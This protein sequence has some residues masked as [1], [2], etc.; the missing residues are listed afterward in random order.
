MAGLILILSCGSDNDDPNG[1]TGN[2][3]NLYLQI[4]PSGLNV[5][6]VSSRE[7]SHVVPLQV[8][9]IG[10]GTHSDFTAQIN[11]WTEDDLVAYNNKEK[12]SY[13]LLPSSLYSLS[14]KELAFKQ[15]E[16]VVDVEIKFAPS[17]VFNEFKKHGSEYVIALKLT[18]DKL[19]IR[20]RQGDILLPISFDYPIIHFATSVAEVSV[21]KDQVPVTIN[22]V[23]DFKE[24][25]KAITN[26]WNFACKFSVPANAEELVAAYNQSYKTSCQLLPANNYDLGEGASFQTGNNQGTGEITIKREGLAV[27]SYLLPLKLDECSN[28]GVVCRDE[29]CYLQVGKTYSNPIITDKSVPDPCVIRANDGYFY[30]YATHTDKYWMPIYRS[31]DLVNW[32][33]LRTAFTNAT[34][35]TLPGGGSFWA[36]EIKYINGKYVLYFS[37][38]KMNGADVS[39][40]AVATSDSPLGPFVPSIEL[41]G[42]A[43]FGSNAIDQFYYEEDGKKY[44]FF[45]SFKGIFVVELADDGLSVKRDI[46]GKPV[47]KK[48]VCG[49]AFEGTNI[50]KKDGYY[51]LFASIGSCCA[52]VNSSYKVV[53]G[54]STNL[55][56]PY[57]DKTGKDMLNNAW[58]LV[59]EGDGQKWIGPGHNAEIIRDDE[60][61]DWM[62]YHSYVKKN[63]AVGGRLGM[64]D[65]LHWSADGWPT[66]KKC[67][68]S[69]SDLIPVFYD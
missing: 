20:D 62:I 33:Y 38:A 36:P 48:Q 28:E 8:K 49:N 60:G 32:E 26:P 11:S 67:V 61:T 64:L 29:I 2:A 1:G 16:T 25:G 58:E 21:T 27:V 4:Q 47:L 37:W 9:V 23:F 41:I 7:D 52:G 39:Y 59:L 3:T 35:P 40:T 51:Y 63:N 15:G 5:V 68:P 18:C 55:L 57:L 34:K 69:S 6:E 53:V 19:K 50:Y 44:M 12:K 54:R 43:E 31:K 30:L 66:I 24:N 17:N 22:T 46:N 10:N 45:G 65:R 13:A 14:S 42:N 56:G